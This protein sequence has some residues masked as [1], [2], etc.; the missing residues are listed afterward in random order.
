MTKT[1]S[2]HPYAAAPSMK[3]RRGRRWLEHVAAAVITVALVALL[4]PARL[5]AGS[6]TRQMPAGR[7]RLLIDRAWRFQKGDAPGA[8]LSS[9]T[10][11]PWLLPTSNAFVK[12][13][14]RRRARPEGRLGAD[15]PYAQPDFDD[16]EWRTLDLP[17]DWGVEGSFS[18]TGS[19][20]RGRLP[21]YGV[22]WY[23]KTLD[24]PASDAGR[25]IFLDVDGAMSYAAVWINGEFA[26]GW[27][28]G[29]A[30]WRVD[31]TPYLKPGGRNVVAIRLDNPEDASR[32]YPGGGIYR[33]VW[34]VKA[35]PIHVGEWGTYVT[36]PSVSAES[37]TVSTRIAVDNDSAEDAT[38]TVSSEIVPLDAHGAHA[39]A[40]VATTAA[41]SIRV[42]H[43]SSAVM[44]QDAAVAHPRLWGP[45]PRQTPNRY[46]L[47]TTVTRDG[48]VLDRYETP[49]GI[50]T[51]KFDAN[52]GFS[53][54]GEPLDF[55][56][57][58]MHHD[59]GALG[60]ALSDRALER[61]L[62]MLIDMGVNAIRTSHNPPAPELLEYA[63][64]KGLLVLDEA[65]DQWQLQKRPL[66]YHLLFD[67]WHEQDLRALIRRDRNHPSVVMWSVGNEVGEQNRGDAGTAVAAM[68]TGIAHDEDPT[69]PTTSA[70]N[71]ARAASTFPTGVDVIGL[72]Y[73]GTGVRGGP[74]QYP[75]F[76]QQFPNTFIYGSETASTIS[77]RGEYTFPVASGF[78]VPASATAGEDVARRQLSSYDLYSAPW[79]YS[80]DK[81]F[82]SQ[83][84]FPYV[85]GEFVWTGFDYLGEPTPFDASRSSYFGTIDLAG[86]KKDRFYLYQAH[87]RPDLKMAHILPHWNWPERVGLKDANGA[88]VPTPVHVY[89]SG[90]EGELFLNGKSL[91]RKTRGPDDFRLR[92][93]DVIYEPGTLRVVTYKNGRRWATD[94]V[95]TTGPA[96]R[97]G[98][99]ADR[100]AIHGDGVD[101]VFITASIED[102][103]GL[104]VPRSHNRLT[105]TVDGPGHLVATDNG[106]PTSVE[107]FLSPSRDAFNG[108]ALVVVRANRGATGT[109]RV[110]ATADGLK[111]DV[112]T[113]KV[114]P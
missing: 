34:L 85:G 59:L 41:S 98:L 78:G 24:I 113:V 83:A 68:L 10:L 52:D 72:N 5:P 91:G 95:K 82:Q 48:V 111:T 37:A 114:G 21:F 14:T 13:A 90:D 15:L 3:M 63:D 53:I 108:L 29:Y 106:D 22:G 94:E 61:Q 75:V 103:K 12:D 17:H 66:D 49:F 26:G 4:A 99:S 67:D 88:P 23:R 43:G 86:F 102:A 8:T 39:G 32:W 80:P 44:E 2:P 104:T 9:S 36:T 55:Q 79:S 101:L 60:A 100:A 71:S 45:P 19:G 56:G 54:N 40:A 31:L 51:I 65:F 73:Q 20:A 28:Y 11:L 25:S 38:V 42:P 84:R 69:R 93:D 77:S 33:H 81:E 92:W 105:F 1:R 74:P 109:I 110:T 97:V 35:A 58:C 89:T 76:H 50:R 18:T 107:S 64:E 16:R 30:S 6:A 112:V 62:D 87:W 7:E 46:A 57:V 47:V 27:P 70:M 96:A